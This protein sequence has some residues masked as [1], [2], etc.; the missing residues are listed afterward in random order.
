MRDLKGRTLR[1]GLAKGGAQIVNFLLRIGC[2]MILARILEPGDFGLVGMVTAITGVLGLFKEFGL[3]TATVQRDNIT[4]EQVSALFWINIAVGVALAVASAGIAPLVADFYREPRL[5]L[6]MSILGVGFIFNAAGVQHSAVLQRQMRFTALAVIDIASLV[7]SSAAAIVIATRGYGYWALVAWTV[8]APLA[9]TLLTWQ[10]SAWF[11]GGPS[12]RS[13]VRLLLRFGSIVT[14]NNLI[15]YVAYNLDKILLGRSFGA[16]VVGIYGRAYQLVTL[17]TDQINSTV[18]S[19]A[20][21]VLS[22][23]QSDPERLKRY[24]LRSYA[25]VL[26]ITIPIAFGGILFAQELILIVFGSK[27]LEAVPIFRM[28]APTLL[29]FALINPTGW[30]LVSIGMVG[31]SLRLALAIAPLVISGYLFGLQF[32]A[33]GVALGFSCAMMLWAIPHLIW[34]FHGTVITFRDLVVT[35]GRPLISGIVSALCV[36]GLYALHGPFES[37]MLA[38]G[39]GSMVL[40]SVYII[41]LLFVM[42]QKAFYVELFRALKPS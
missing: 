3:S 24:F 31:R 32:G 21:P 7:I 30:F 14:F 23:L 20:I 37:E 41:I 36:I 18:G 27:W 34:C 25:L 11:P 42:G 35:I 13:D 5:S 15:I 40:L 12:I 1:G 29:V 19:I 6:V 2:L 4:Q 26:T 38:L 39:V 33:K 9:T 22:R 16:E 17:P 28:L 10:Q 8:T